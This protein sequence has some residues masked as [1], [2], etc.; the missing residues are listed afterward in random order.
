MPRRLS[1]LL[2]LMPG[3][4][5]AEALDPKALIEAAMEH[6]RGLTSY[7]EMTM[8][9]HRPDWERSMSMRS[10]SEGDKKSLIRVTA[11][12]QDRGNG[13]L[14]KDGRMWTFSP[15]VNR[16]VK[17]P[18]SIMSQSWMGSD[19]SNNEIS[20]STDILYEY[21]HRLLET[22]RE[23][24][25]TIY[26]IEAIP[27]EEAPVVWGREIIHIRDD[28]VMLEEQFWDQDDILVKTMRTHRVEEMSGRTVATVMRMNRTDEPDEWTEV[29]VDAI[30]FDIEL[31]SSLFTLSNLRNPR[32]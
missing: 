2:F 10:W 19:F 20:K 14:T 15:K 13:T 30:E 4:A 24:G 27:H 11:P 23:D 29:R 31:P 25:H 18:S 26:V 7:G 9:V 16:V 1:L 3:P 12:K 6:W 32:E 28:Y 17:V 21:D 8:I 5:A 22:Y